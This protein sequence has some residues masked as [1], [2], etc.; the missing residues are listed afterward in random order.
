MAPVIIGAAHVDRIGHAA[1]PV[2]GT[3]VPGRVNRSFGGVGRNVAATLGLLGAGPGLIGVVGADTDGAALIADLEARGVNA[4]RM[5]RLRG[6][7]TAS[8]HAILEADGAL[9]GAVADMG[10]YRELAP[11]LL[12]A[13]VPAIVD[14]ELVFVDANLPAQTLAWLAGLD[15]RGRLAADCVSP[16]K[17]GK[18]R[19]VISGLDL[20]FCNLA[21]GAVLAGREDGGAAGTA[22]SLCAAGAGAAVVTDGAGEV[23]WC[24]RG[25]EPVLIAV[26]PA[27]PVDVT[28]A[29]DALAAAC[30]YGLHAGHGLASSVAAGMVA[31]RHAIARRGADLDREAGLDI[32]TRLQ[33][34]T[35]R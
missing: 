22:L 5:R 9:L 25:G 18:L 17:A 21:E 30:L 13:D 27:A 16:H 35:G 7:T 8:Y 14:A 33:Q 15:R 19:A 23:C 31:A 1:G 28:G 2:R 26:P 4:A 3:S 32:I 6:R 29:G 24:R 10:I 20:V 12:A 34:E 11:D